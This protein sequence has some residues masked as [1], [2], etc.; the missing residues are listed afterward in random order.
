MQCNAR[1]G[2]RYRNYDVGDGSLAGRLGGRKL[3][4]YRV[5]VRGVKV[6]HHH[7]PDPSP[8]WGM[9]VPRSQAVIILTVGVHQLIWAQD[10]DHGQEVFKW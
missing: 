5:K 3:G 1:A 7:N 10:L 8:S 4:R 2:K 6:E 9:I